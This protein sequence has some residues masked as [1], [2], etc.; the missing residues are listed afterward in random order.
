MSKQGPFDTESAE[1][2]LG[3]LKKRLDHP[4][5]NG[6][7]SHTFHLGQNDKPGIEAAILILEAASKITERQFLLDYIGEEIEFHKSQEQWIQAEILETLY[8]LLEAI[9]E[10]ATLVTAKTHKHI[11]GVIEQNDKEAK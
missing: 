11:E 8:A 2:I 10:E 4:D 3:V 6:N 7:I 9:P 5:E 1:L